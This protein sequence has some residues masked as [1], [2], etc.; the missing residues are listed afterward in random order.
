MSPPTS[1]PDDPSY[2]PSRARVFLRLWPWWRPYWWALALMPMADVMALVI[3]TIIPFV[4]AGMID[5]P[6]AKGDHAGL[7]SYGGILLLLAVAQTLFFVL[8]FFPPP[9][10]INVE[11]AIRRDLYHHVQRL[12]PLYHDRHGGGVA[13]SHLVGDVSQIAVGLHQILPQLASTATALVLTSAMLIFIH[14]VLGLVV[15]IGLVPLGFATGV[16]QKLFYSAADEARESDA[17]LATSIEESAL[18][19]RVLKALGGGPFMMDRF[20]FAARRSR[21]AEI[22][23]IR[24]NSILAAILTGYPIALLA[25]VIGGGSI[26]VAHGAVSIGAFVAFTTFY[27]RV[28]GPVNLMGNTLFQF[29]LSMNAM[30]RVAQLLDTPSDIVDPAIPRVLPASGA[31]DVRFE[32]VCFSY[33]GAQAEVLAG[34]DLT[35][36]AGETIAIVGSTGSGKSALANLVG[37]LADVTGGRVLVGGIDVRDVAIDA[38]RGTVGMAFEDALLFSVSVRE[39]LTLGRE[40]ISDHDIATMLAITQSGFVADLPGGLDTVVGERGLTLSGG[41][42]QRL[43]LARA[44]LGEPRVLVLDDPMSALDVRT[45]E[46]L[47]RAFR[48]AFKGVT[49][50]IVARRPSTALLADRVALL[51]KGRIAAVGT[52]DELLANSAAYRQVLIAA[53]D[54]QP[55]AEV[56]DAD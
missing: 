30:T 55:A 8:R 37:R 32:N 4:V 7:W 49:T 40:G 56:A 21:D 42:R 46:A 22:K 39:N 13:L 20:D 43:A 16:F 2:P 10:I 11:M 48:Q 5:G 33:P 3:R 54:A 1:P 17:A 6:I 35:I 47:E 50:L 9:V 23:K 38:L 41:Q 26:S 27:F 24:L 18:A 14:P 45:E 15:V 25:V 28:L 36:H 44:L 29:Q 53:T 19:I 31:L 12:S 51:E 52:H 34:V